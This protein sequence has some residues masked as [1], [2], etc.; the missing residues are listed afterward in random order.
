[1]NPSWVVPVM[2]ALLG[3]GFFVGVGQVITALTKA[4]TARIQD[5]GIVTSSSLGGA[6]QA[7]ALMERALSR[8]EKEVEGLKTDRDE[9]RKRSREK[10]SRI[11]ELEQELIRLR[12]R[13]SDI[14]TRVDQSVRRVQEV[15]H[16][17]EDPDA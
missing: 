13:L 2:T 6:E 1:M 16:E 14:S 3:G 12:T 5:S 11:A 8:A 7:I 9:E 10:D 17:T 4:R 15:R